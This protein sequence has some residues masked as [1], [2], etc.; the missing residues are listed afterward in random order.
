MEAGECAVDN[1]QGRFIC[2]TTTTTTTI[3]TT[4]TT[5]TKAEDNGLF[6]KV[7][8]TVFGKVRD[9]AII[10]SSLMGSLAKGLCG[11]S[12]ELRGNLQ[13]LCLIASGKGVEILRRIR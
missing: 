6:G 11:K 7:R 1:G 5:T 10:S 3:A 13:K 9:T 2:M 12:A 4:T 8:D